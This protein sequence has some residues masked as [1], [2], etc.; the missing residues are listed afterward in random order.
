MKMNLLFACVLFAVSCAYAADHKRPMEKLSRGLVAIHLPEKGVYLGWRLL[1]T[2]PKTIAFDVYRDGQK[3]NPAPILDST[4][5]MDAH[6]K[7]NSRYRVQA[8]VNGKPA[9]NSKVVIPREQPYRH[10]KLTPPATVA[11]PDGKK[12]P[13]QIKEAAVGDLDG[14]GDYELVIEWYGI[15]KDVSHGGYT[16]PTVL[17][18]IEMDGTS[19]WQIQMG[20]NVR[21]GEHYTQV[22]VFDLDGDGK[23]EVACR[24]SDGTTDGKGK[25]IGD[26]KK[27]YRDK[28]GRVLRAPE[29]LT[30]FNGQTG[31]AI[32]TVSYEPARGAVKTWGDK[33]GNRCERHTSCIAYLDGKNP[34]IVNG[35][36]YYRA[37]PGRT[38]LAAW[39]FVDGKLK[40][41]WKFDTW[42]KK[43]LHDYIGQ[44]THSIATGDVDG[45]GKD[46][47][48]YGAM[49][50]DDDGKPL[51]S[52][53]LQHGDAHHFGDLDP[54][55]P[56]LE[57]YMPHEKAG[58]PYGRAGLDRIPGMSFRDAR[59]GEILWSIPVLKDCDIGRGG[60]EDIWAGSPGAE[61]WTGSNES[62]W[63]KENAGK[64]FSCKGKVIGP[65]P[66]V[67]AG[68][69]VWWDGDLTREILNRNWVAKY[70]PN[71]KDALVRILTE[72]GAAVTRG[73]KNETILFADLFGDWR[74]EILW[75]A[76][77]GKGFYLYSTTIPT[78]HRIPT[79]MHDP[80]YRL[81]VAWQNNVYNQPPHTGHTLEDLERP[82]L[83]K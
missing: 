43:E 6:G 18:A 4:N 2:D 62:T 36:G 38:G 8:V 11:L 60:C 30:V 80:I 40:M 56:G 17:Q 78:T 29:Y 72:D 82:W 32:D 21:S 35:R 54:A 68:F 25:V 73:G 65:A 64:L 34:S 10:V 66:V 31:A 46:E 77:D 22:M 61:T 33:Y 20:I 5:Y 57:F 83:V 15:D 74:E 28:K 3:V 41:R 79:L 12:E 26:A 71:A 53:N 70:D 47:I 58:R 7:G 75:K 63:G 19:L 51:Y 81:S 76:K 16:T 24:T 37:N 39:D 1:G 44:G 48:L 49:A 55:R 59:T 50:I 23:A 42:K 52:T 14:D 69:F 45:D 13:Y 9:G 27:D 67:S